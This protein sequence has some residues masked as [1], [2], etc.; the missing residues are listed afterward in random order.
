M[1]SL[2]VAGY[3]VEEGAKLRGSIS[4][5]EL[6]DGSDVK[7][8]LLLINGSR[9]GPKLYIGAAIHGDEVNGIAL[10]ARALS[11]VDPKQLA[12][13]IVCVPV[14][15]PLALQSDHRLPLSQFLKSP[16]D[17]M[18][19]DAWTC[20]PGDAQGNI[21]Q[22]IAAQLF[23]LIKTCDYAIDIHTPTRGGRYV[24]IAILP[25]P[26]LPSFDK[27]E[28]LAR[29]LGNGWIMRGEEGMYVSDGIL[30]VEAT[31]AGIPCFTFEI[32]EGGRLEEESVATGAQCVTNLLIHLKMI[33]G[34]RKEPRETHTMRA[35]VG[36]RANRAGLLL[37]DVPLGSRP[38]KGD[39]VC[40]I[41]D[42]FGATV[43]E[44]LAPVEGL[45]VRSTTLSTVSRGERV[46]T[47]GIV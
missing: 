39:R 47:L 22:V 29:G 23:A 7:I 13:S 19:A 30:C 40:R 2:S 42:V 8:P 15:H 32:G 17:Q 45:F 41:L 4:A 38:V 18:P 46:A 16:L 3:S 37:T 24:P 36:I 6:A 21:A 34:V 31:R 10:V 33:D 9:P 1:P 5:L 20:F 26:K 28:D 11:A 25:D 35:F 12:G 44:V 27:V 14:Q 43:E